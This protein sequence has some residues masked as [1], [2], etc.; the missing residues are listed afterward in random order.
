MLLSHCVGSTGDASSLGRA[1]AA[2]LLRNIY[3]VVLGYG[4]NNDWFNGA[5]TFAEMGGDSLLAIEAAHKLSSAIRLRRTVDNQSVH[6]VIT[7]VDLMEHPSSF[8]VKCIEEG[9]IECI[10]GKYRKKR[11]KEEN[12]PIE[13]VNANTL[14]YLGDAIMNEYSNSPPCGK[15]FV[16]V[17]WKCP[18][19]MCVDAPPLVIRHDLIGEIVMVGSQG[20]DIL[21]ACADTGKVLCRT[22]LEGKI[23]GGMNVLKVSREV[24]EKERTLVFVCT[25]GN[26]SESSSRLGALHCFELDPSSSSFLTPVWKH[27][28]PGEL[29]GKP[30]CFCLGGTCPE[31]N[32]NN[33]FGV[34]VSGYDGVALYLDALTGYEIGQCKDLGG[35]VHASPSLFWLDGSNKKELRAIVASA[36]WSGQVTCLSITATSVSKVWAV[37]CWAPIYACPLIWKDKEPDESNLLSVLFGSVDGSIRRLNAADGGEIWRENSVKQKPIFSGCCP[38]RTDG[39]DS[40]VFGSHDGYVSCVSIKDGR[41][42]WIFDSRASVVATP[43]VIQG[44]IVIAS[45]S[46]MIFYVDSCNGKEIARLHDCLGGEV[47]SSPCRDLETNLYVYCG[48]RDNCLYKVCKKKLPYLM[49]NTE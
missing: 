7:A 19:L 28:V 40:V 26:T 9:L 49:Q 25:Y 3:A 33:I 8:I 23:E 5:L 13:N 27:V 24:A 15:A 17:V 6:Y 22:A 14:T 21:C 12:A 46:G 35:A 37:N 34:I 29:K 32:E 45:T 4:G 16:D 36:T 43:L 44:Y 2:E 47:F 38:V 41:R 20:G 1:P 42:Q 11:K 18:L 31:S 48:S 39:K 30:A 10:G